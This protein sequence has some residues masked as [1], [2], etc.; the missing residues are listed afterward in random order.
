MNFE[1]GSQKLESCDCNCIT[2]LHLLKVYTDEKRGYQFVE[3]TP[4]CQ[5]LQ[6]L[7]MR[8]VISDSAE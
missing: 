2:V 4:R 3:T 7:N 6:P 1:C 8:V 5:K